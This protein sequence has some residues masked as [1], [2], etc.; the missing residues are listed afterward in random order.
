MKICYA[1]CGSYCTLADSVVQLKALAAAGHEIIPVGSF[2]FADV[3]TRFGQGLEWLSRVREISGREVINT[4]A[5]AEPVGPVLQPDVMIIAPCTGNTLAKLATGV[6]DTPVTL[7]AKSH[8]RNK[9]PLIIALSS[10]DALGANFK[11]IA[12]LYEKK[13]V[14]FVP[15]LQDDVEQKPYSLSCDFAKIPETLAMA[16]EG[17]QLLP[18]FG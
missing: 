5:A 2:N 16:M 6:S 17:R 11:N 12:A 10:N 9:R 4:I 15:L 7:A 1:F 3:D 18:L 8:L 14:Y 13:Y